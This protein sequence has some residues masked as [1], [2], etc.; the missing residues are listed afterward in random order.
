MAPF[1]L[2]DEMM[3]LIHEET[4]AAKKGKTARIVIKVNSL[5]DPD[6]IQSLYKASQAGEG[7]TDSSWDL[8][9]GAWSKGIK[10]KYNCEKF[11]G[12]VSRA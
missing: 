7:G 9:I 3:R 6:A 10:R 4:T 1:N 5:I 2:H 8:W 11:T 12:Q